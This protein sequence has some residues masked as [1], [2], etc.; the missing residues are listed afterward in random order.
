MPTMGDWTRLSWA[1]HVAI[2]IRI[3][4]DPGRIQ[5]RR[6]APGNC[7]SGPVLYQGRVAYGTMPGLDC[8]LATQMID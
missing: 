1:A 3:V 5:K 6:N 8:W 7:P 2:P 4:C